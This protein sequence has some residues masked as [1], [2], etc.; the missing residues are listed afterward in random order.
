MCMF[1][2]FRFVNCIFCWCTCLKWVVA[3]DLKPAGWWFLG[4]RP[5]VFMAHYVS[6]FHRFCT[7][8]QKQG[9][10]MGLGYRF[11]CGA[12]LRLFSHSIQCQVRSIFS[13]SIK[14]KQMLTSA[15]RFSR[16]RHID[17]VNWLEILRACPNCGELDLPISRHQQE[18]LQPWH[19][20]FGFILRPQYTL[21]NFIRWII[22]FSEAR[23]WRDSWLHVW[24]SRDG[25]LSRSA[26]R[27]LRGA[28]LRVFSISIQWFTVS[29]L[30][31][32]LKGSGSCEY[33]LRYSFPT[34]VE[35]KP[36][37]PPVSFPFRQ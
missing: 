4:R 20:D 23:A 37:A 22:G 26:D 16:L 2:P 36:L 35:A 31:Y 33:M 32:L 13:S 8:L 30:K 21:C 10:L 12:P 34:P 14:S 18:D 28:P 9:F 1:S 5:E 29:R 17:G 27:F 25:D 11:L 3:T 7:N 24:C 6:C 15:Q 19:C